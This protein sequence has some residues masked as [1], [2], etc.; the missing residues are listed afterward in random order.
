MATSPCS[1]TSRR[2]T[3]R[4]RK[5]ASRP[6]QTSTYVATPVSTV[7]G[8]NGPTESPKSLVPTTTNATSAIAM[9][10]T[11]LARASASKSRLGLRADG[12]SMCE[13]DGGRQRYGAR[14]DF[15]VKVLRGTQ[16]R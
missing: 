14:N 9:I 13:T 16:K 4:A 2:A 8:A 10:Q 5:A 1:L 11:T 3:A 12:V 7:C 6:M 15:R